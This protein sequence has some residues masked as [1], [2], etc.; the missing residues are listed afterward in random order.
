MKRLLFILF[1][2][3]IA[4][5]EKDDSS[6][7]TA[8]AVNL[9]VND[10]S[11]SMGED[12]H[13]IIQVMNADSLFA[14][15]FE[16]NY[17]SDLKASKESELCILAVPT[18]SLSAILDDLNNPD[19]K[20]YGSFIHKHLPYTYF[21]RTYPKRY[22]EVRLPYYQNGKHDDTHLSYTGAKMI[23]SLA[24]Q[25]IARQGLALENYIKPQVL[26]AEIVTLKD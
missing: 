8:L 22:P 13:L 21:M 12:L 24:L 16:L 9:I 25:E 14:L 15:S 2:L 6:P 26:E 19:M 23:A 3:I 18:H 17:S 7:S 10:K 1:L 4:C 20:Y 5:S 11:M